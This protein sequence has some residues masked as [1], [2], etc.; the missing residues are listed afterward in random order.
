MGS[1]SPLLTESVL[2]TQS[3]RDCAVDECR[4]C[5]RQRAE[6]VVSNTNGLGATPCWG[7][8]SHFHRAGV[9][10]QGHVGLLGKEWP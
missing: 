6:P 3:L 8:N 9:A 1:E 10:R 4:V 2:T 5:E 7:E